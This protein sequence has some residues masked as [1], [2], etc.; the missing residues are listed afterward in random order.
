MRKSVRTVLAT[1]LLFFAA[2]CRGDAVTDNVR[3]DLKTTSGWPVVAFIGSSSFAQDRQSYTGDPWLRNGGYDENSAGTPVRNLLAESADTTHVT[4]D[5][6]WFE[7]VTRNVYSASLDVDLKTLKRDP[8]ATDF[9]VLIFRI[10]PDGIVQAVT[11]DESYP[12]K[13]PPASAITVAQ[14]CGAPTRLDEGKRDSL[15]FALELMESNEDVGAW[16][17]HRWDDADI[18]THCN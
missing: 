4:F 15:A 17:A 12:P 2:A 5:V 6:T 16:F 1:A 10:S 3:Y 9:N 18:P 14:A 8:I 13:E 7:V 11:Y